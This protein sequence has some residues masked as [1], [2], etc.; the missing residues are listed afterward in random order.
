MKTIIYQV[1]CICLLAFSGC[2]ERIAK[3]QQPEGPTPKSLSLIAG[4]NACPIYVQPDTAPYGKAL[5]DY[6]KRMS[7]KDFQIVQL[8]DEGIPDGPAV[9]VMA[10]DSSAA[11]KGGDS[12]TIRTEDGKL[13]IVGETS[14]AAGFAVFAFLEDVLGCRWWSFN[15]EDVPKDEVLTIGKLDIAVK[16]PL[17]QTELFNLEARTGENNF[18]YKSRA[19]NSEQF[20]GAHTLYPM[21]KGYAASHPEIFPMNKDGRRAGNDLHFCYLAPGI[22]DALSDALEKVIAEKNGNVK[23]WIYFAGMGD[24]YGGICE[25]PDCKKVYDEETW[26]DLDGKKYPGYSA[27]LL[28]MMNAVGEKL[29]TKYP[30][31]R[32]G[33]FAYMSLDAPPGVTRPRSNVAIWMPHLRYCIAHP[34]EGCDKN[35][36]FLMK[37]Q[38]WCE[39]APGNVYIWDY[40]VNFGQN[41]MF[42]TPVIRSTAARLKTYARLGCSGVMLQGNYVSYG[43]DL[44]VLK[45]YVWR[46]LMWNPDLDSDALIGEFCDAY[47]GPAAPAVKRYVCILEDAAGKGGDFDEFSV[48]DTMKKTFLSADMQRD[49]RAI[50]DEALKATGGQEPYLRRVKEAA[51]SLE[52]FDM[53]G[54]AEPH[55]FVYSPKDGYLAVNGVVTW[56][57]AEALLQYSRNCSFGEWGQPRAY[58]ER[59][60]RLH[61]GL[62]PH[63]KQGDVELDVAVAQGGSIYQITFNGKPLLHCQHPNPDQKQAKDIPVLF[64]GSFENLAVSTEDKQPLSHAFLHETARQASSITMEGDADVPFWGPIQHRI[65]KTVELLDG[66]I[67]RITGK[68][69]P[70]SGKGEASEQVT[71]VTDYSVTPGTDFKVESSADGTTWKPVEL[72]KVFNNVSA[73]DPNNVQP[74]RCTAPGP[75]R[76]L[77]ISLPGSGVVVTDSYQSMA[78]AKPDDPELAAGLPLDKAEIIWDAAAGVL[79]TEATAPADPAGNW[80]RREMKFKAQ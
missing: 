5:A 74:L 70:T 33:T 60:L 69:I 7:G 51:A 6:L 49:L 44:I 39:I 10:A 38:R 79:T 56:P 18:V 66:G 47:Y 54:N 75:V 35:R 28:R 80:P 16:A 31:V 30:G 46:R 62:L 17:R 40:A 11:R 24:W 64:R 71:T 29:E 1:F 21:L 37:L 34:L 27:T 45:N 57:L 22:S 26:T 13:L 50:L 77:R 23:D 12:F 67:M 4:M 14:R 63:F 8:K 19:I 59:F 73:G 32:V 76:Q 61:G 53:I 52:A 42:P 15:E 55:K 3:L 43:S 65:Q 2:A 9:M 78:P 68:S 25:C 58:H 48:A 20:T 72:S 36:A 41:F